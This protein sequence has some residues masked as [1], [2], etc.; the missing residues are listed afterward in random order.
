M[1]RSHARK[2]ELGC[3][4]HKSFHHQ[5]PLQSHTSPLGTHLRRREDQSAFTTSSMCASSAIGEGPEAHNFRATRV[6][7]NSGTP[8]STGTAGLLDTHQSTYRGHRG[9]APNPARASAN[10]RRNRR[11]PGGQ[12]GFLPRR[13]ESAQTKNSQQAPAST[14]PARV[15]ANER[16]NRRYPGG[17]EGFLSGRLESAQTKQSQQETA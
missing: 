10:G 2:F 15:S 16:R 12:E 7:A 5:E 11:Y 14:K 8:I 9:G 6:S 13:L 17:Q 4:R 3:L 1:P